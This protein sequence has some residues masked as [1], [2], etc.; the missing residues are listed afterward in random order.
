MEAFLIGAGSLQSPPGDHICIQPYS[1][2]NLQYIVHLKV[3]IPNGISFINLTH[4]YKVRTQ[5]LT[6]SI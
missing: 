6:G 4:F 1:A 3:R 5:F 2:Q